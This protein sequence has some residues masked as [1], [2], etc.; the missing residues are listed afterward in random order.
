MLA[1]EPVIVERLRA[2][3]DP[4]QPDLRTEVK[5]W[6]EDG[7]RKAAQGRVLIIV[8]LAGTPMG[9]VSKVAAAVNLGWWIELRTKRAPIAAGLLDRCFAEVMSGLHGWSPQPAGGRQWMQL[10]YQST[11]P[12]EGIDD[13]VFGL[14]MYFQTAAIYSGK[15]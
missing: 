8:R 10:A 3:L 15:R 13:G 9:P 7:D 11:E 12:A 2:L 14:S 1:L 5:G 6:S 4:L